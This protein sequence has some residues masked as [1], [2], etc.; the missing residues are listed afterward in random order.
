[1]RSRRGTPGR[2]AR[3][4]LEPIGLEAVLS[5]R[6]VLEPDALALLLVAGQPIA[7]GAPQRVAAE[8]HHAVEASSVQR[9]YDAACSA[10]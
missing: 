2:P 1:M 6:V 8:L 3:D 5:Q 9:Q 10:P 4:I 7:A